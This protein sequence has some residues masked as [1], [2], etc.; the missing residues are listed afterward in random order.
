MFEVC[1][2]LTLDMGSNSE[3]ELE[4]FADGST[5]EEVKDEINGLVLYLA[6]EEKVHGNMYLEIEIT[7]NGEFV[8]SDGAEIFV[9]GDYSGYNILD[10]E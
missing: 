9:K 6:S 8:E 3:M 7:E 2:N 5:L 4:A 10:I 1:V